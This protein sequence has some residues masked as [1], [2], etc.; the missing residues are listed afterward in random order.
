MADPELESALRNQRGES[1]NR[2][3]Y[4]SGPAPP[5]APGNRNSPKG[6]GLVEEISAEVE[7]GI[8]VMDAAFTLG[9]IE[10]ETGH[11]KPALQ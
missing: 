1:P 11:R 4:A 6:N 8:A 9:A 3:R 10:T 5:D 2:T 7:V